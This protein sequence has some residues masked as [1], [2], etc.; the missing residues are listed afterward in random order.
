MTPVLRAK[1]KDYCLSLGEK[2]LINEE[3]IGASLICPL[4]GWEMPGGLRLKTEGLGYL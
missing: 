1:V 2:V 3:M 4:L